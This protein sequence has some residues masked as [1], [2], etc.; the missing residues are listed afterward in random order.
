MIKIFS[1]NKNISFNKNFLIITILLSQKIKISRK[2]IS[3]S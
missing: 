2:K 3:Y 1:Y